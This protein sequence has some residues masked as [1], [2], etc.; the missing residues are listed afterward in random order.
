MSGRKLKTAAP[1]TIPSAIAIR[2]NCVN[3]FAIVLPLS[4]SGQFEFGR[5]QGRRN[6]LRSRTICHNV[7]VVERAP[8][9]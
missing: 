8:D 1:I 4:V 3:L 5:F 6:K 2:M 7:F 9:D